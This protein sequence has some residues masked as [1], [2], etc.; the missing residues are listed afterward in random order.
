LDRKIKEACKGLMPES[1]WLIKL[2]LESDQDKEFLA[3][4]ILQWSDHGDGAM[5]SPNTKRVYITALVYLLRYVKNL[6]N[7]GRIY[8]SFKEMTRDDFFAKEEPRGYL[9]SLK[10]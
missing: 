10:L 1:Q 4:F 2:E 7:G 3:D 5:M 6:R 8:K 9:E